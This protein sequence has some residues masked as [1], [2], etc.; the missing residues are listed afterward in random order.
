M[1]VVCVV[2]GVCGVCVCVVCVCMCGVCVC[3]VCMHVCGG[4]GVCVLLG[5]VASVR[6]L[7][8]AVP[9]GPAHRLSPKRGA[10]KCNWKLWPECT[11]LNPTIWA[12]S[13]KQPFAMYDVRPACFDFFKANIKAGCIRRNTETLCCVGD[14]LVCSYLLTYLLHGAESFLRS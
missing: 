10:C 14:M 3:G 4:D 12:V 2:C 5:D 11:L 1:C 8:T 7:N 6:R 9:V 13:S